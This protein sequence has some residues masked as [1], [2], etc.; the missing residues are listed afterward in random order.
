MANIPA[1]FKPP[2]APDEFVTGITDKPE[3]QIQV[4]IN[5]IFLDFQP[6]PIVD[7]ALEEPVYPSGDICH[8]ADARHA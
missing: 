5:G 1:D 4:G 7:A 8:P 3:D 2:V 6:H